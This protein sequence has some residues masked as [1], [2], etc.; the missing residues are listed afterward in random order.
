MGLFSKLLGGIIKT[1]KKDNARLL[2]LIGRYWKTPTEKVYRSVI[3]ELMYG[4]SFLMFPTQNDPAN[5]PD[6]WT[7]MEKGSTLKLACM[8]KV[9]GLIVMNVFTDAQA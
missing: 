9:N 4:N 5:V 3:T 8:G 6:T 2:R 1:D 7:T